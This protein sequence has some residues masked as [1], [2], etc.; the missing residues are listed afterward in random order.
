LVEQLT[1]NQQVGGSSPLAS[2]IVEGCPS[3]QREQ[4]VNLPADAF[5]GSNPIPSTILFAGLFYLKQI[6]SETAYRNLIENIFP[7][8]SVGKNFLKPT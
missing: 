3:G 6:I 8:S 5:I 4:T 7:K 2:S 1:C